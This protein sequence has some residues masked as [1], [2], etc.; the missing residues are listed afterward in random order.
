M[1]AIQAV[2]QKK[3]ANAL[4]IIAAELRGTIKHGAVLT[5][6]LNVD[7]IEVEVSLNA[8]THIDSRSAHEL[9]QRAMA[10]LAKEPYRDHCDK[11]VRNRSVWSRA[12]LESR[13]G[14]VVRKPE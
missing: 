8:R 12:T 3:I 7:G 13:V 11:S 4:E 10:L 5:G 1:K 14:R 6:T 9:R 2:R